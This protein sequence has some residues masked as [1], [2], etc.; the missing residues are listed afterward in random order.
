[1]TALHRRGV[2][3]AALTPVTEALAPD[4]ALFVAH[5]RRL[6]EEGCDGIA[7]L[8]TTGEANSLSSDER[9]ALLESFVGA[10]I[11]PDRLWP[12]AGVAARN[13]AS[14]RWPR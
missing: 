9:G 12:G 14:R 8:S 7:S 11:A 4:H 13:R 10:G 1:M 3:S 6:L 2:F 5:R